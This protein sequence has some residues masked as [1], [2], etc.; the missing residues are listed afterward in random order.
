MRKKYPTLFNLYRFKKAKPLLCAKYNDPDITANVYFSLMI[1]VNNLAHVV[2]QTCIRYIKG[3]SSD[4]KE[5]ILDKN[6]DLE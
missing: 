5:N 1:F 3:S 4:W 6:S 2:F